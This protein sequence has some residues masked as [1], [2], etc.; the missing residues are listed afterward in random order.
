MGIKGKKNA[1]GVNILGGGGYNSWAK[2]SKVTVRY[3]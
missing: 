2:I 1:L 3:F